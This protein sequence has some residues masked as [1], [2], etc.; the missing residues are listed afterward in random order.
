MTMTE[1]RRGR[2]QLTVEIESDLREQIEQSAAQRTLS[3]NEYV[4]S[5]LREAM[6]HDEGD[7]DVGGPGN[8]AALS[9]PTFVRDWQS[10]EDGV[11]DDLPER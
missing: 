5:I 3:V 4:V 9:A 8:W 7:N 2:V 1:Q 10:D 6:A 11:Y